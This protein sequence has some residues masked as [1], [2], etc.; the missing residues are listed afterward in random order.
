VEMGDRVNIEVI[1]DS[2]QLMTFWPSS[3]IP[4]DAKFSFKTDETSKQK[5]LSGFDSNT[6]M[7]FIGDDSINKN[8]NYYLGIRERN[9]L[10]IYSVSMHKMDPVIQLSDETLNDNSLQTPLT[11][12]QQMDEMK[13]KFGSRKTQRSLANKRKY[14]IEFGEDD[15]NDVEFNNNTSTNNSLLETTIGETPSGSGGNI[16]DILPTQNKDAISVDNVYQLNDIINEDEQIIIKELEDEL[17]GAINNTFILSLVSSSSDSTNKMI[18]IYIDLIIQM[19]QL[20]A[21][22]MRRPD[23][24]PHINRRVK[25]FLFERYTYTHQMPGNKSK[26]VI[27]DKE[28]D[29]LL[30]YGIILSIMLYN[31][32]PIDMELLQKSFKVAMR[33]LRRVI[34]IIG[35]YVENSKNSSGVNVKCIVLKI[36]LN[37]YKEGKR[38]R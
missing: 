15:V 35:C 36:P 21:A 31:Y 23:P 16:V 37:T 4:F 24:M 28:K 9:V 34:E 19:L 13:E 38:R 5:K 33:Q 11:V 26:Y 14:A 25:E 7:K 32:R 27:S 3:G 10:K 2:N 1:S 20:K 30:I 12:R 17:F 18:A 29:R 22:D 6:D 8:S